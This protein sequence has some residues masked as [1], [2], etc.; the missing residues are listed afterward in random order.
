MKTAAELAKNG[1]FET[2][3]GS[4]GLKTYLQDWEIIVSN[5]KKENQ[6]D[7]AKKH[8]ENSGRWVSLNK[9]AKMVSKSLNKVIP[10]RH[11]NVFLLVMVK[12]S[13]KNKPTGQT[14]FHKFLA[15]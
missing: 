6:L 9:N 11:F 2:L 3:K 14:F 5:S 7:I 13:L 12:T 4:G 10:W 15:L 8:N 1:K